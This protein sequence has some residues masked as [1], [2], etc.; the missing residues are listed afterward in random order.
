MPFQIL[1]T[2]KGKPLLV[3]EEN[4]HYRQEG[5]DKETKKG[6]R[7]Y[8]ACLVDK[9]EDCKAR[10]V[11]DENNVEIKRSK[12]KHTHPSPIGKTEAIKV[13]NKIKADAKAKKTANPLAIVTDNLQDC[14]Q[15]AANYLPDANALCRN[16]N[17]HKNVGAE[18]N[19]SIRTGWEIVDE[20]FKYYTNGDGEK[21][22]F[23]LHDTGADDEDRILIF[24]QESALEDLK[25]FR[26]WMA[27]STFKARP[28][29]D[30]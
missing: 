6:I 13:K 9:K 2:E 23:L 19:P 18:K 7:R 1:E 26:D 22:L 8:W 24:G 25:K 3:D 27:D 12:A 14:P 17:N 28:C 11:T 10:L 5:K 15:S 16:I 29:L 4:Y 21:K 30:V 20:A